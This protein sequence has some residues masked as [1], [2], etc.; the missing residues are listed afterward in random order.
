MP[1]E[2]Q[3]LPEE[4]DDTQLVLSASPTIAVSNSF[5]SLSVDVADAAGFDG[6]ALSRSFDSSITSPSLNPNPPAACSSPARD[7]LASSGH[8]ATLHRMKAATKRVTDAAKLRRSRRLAEKEGGK[9][10]DMT[11]KAMN[12]KAHRFDLKLAS[13]ELVAALDTSGLTSLPDEPVLDEAAL[14]HIASLCGAEDEEAAEVSSPA[15]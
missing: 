1:E 13:A 2:E 5:A 11:T 7:S 3:A 10:V 12:T 9:F 8:E 15:P 14:A 4:S 6:N